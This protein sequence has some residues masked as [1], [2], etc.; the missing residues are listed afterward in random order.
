M[1]P[2]LDDELA[3]AASEFDTLAELRADVEARLRDQIED[4]V[5]GQF[6]A[7]AV[8]ELVAASKVDAAGPLVEART[9]ELLNAASPA[10]RGARHRRRHVPRR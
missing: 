8:D 6:R 4:E 9:R 7:D 1:L 2:P 5:E 3:G 10:A